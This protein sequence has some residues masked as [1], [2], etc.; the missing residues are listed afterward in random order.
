MGGRRWHLTIGNT[1]NPTPTGPLK[2]AVGVSAKLTAKVAVEQQATVEAPKRARTEDLATTRP[3]WDQVRPPEP[4]G[5]DDWPSYDK[6]FGK[7][8]YVQDPKNAKLREIVGAAAELDPALA[9]GP[10]GTGLEAGK[11]DAAAIKAL[12]Q[13]LKAKGYDLGPAGADGKLGPKTYAALVKYLDNDGGA[14]AP[15]GGALKVDGHG[16]GLI[17]DDE[18]K[19]EGKKPGK[20]PVEIPKKP[21][22][23]VDGHGMGVALPDDDDPKPAPKKSWPT[24]AENFGKAP[25]VQDPKDEKIRELAKAATEVDSALGKPP[26]GPALAAGKLDAEAVKSLQKELKAKGF[27][28]GPAG[29]DGKIGPKTWAALVKFVEEGGKEPPKKLLTVDGHGTGVL[30]DDDEKK[31]AEAKPKAEIPKPKAPLT[32]DGHGT[33]LAIELDAEVRIDV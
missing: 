3:A 18:K 21:A 27:D 33:G 2:P 14:A 28:L 6:L 30:I 32:V 20:A 4:K 17:I 22:P 25:Y 11:L 7:A 15:K 16:T 24:Y 1:G 19:A 12:Q 5:D 10:V 9:K 23:M 26:V 13:H 29:V 31:K 8:P